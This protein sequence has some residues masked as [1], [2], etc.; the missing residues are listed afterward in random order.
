[1]APTPGTRF[2]AVFVA[3][4]L[5]AG[6]SMS[7]A[8]ADDEHGPLIAPS[9]TT[10]SGHTHEVETPA[11]VRIME[12]GNARRYA[13]GQ[14]V[15]YRMTVDQTIQARGPYPAPP[16]TSSLELLL[17]ETVAASDRGLVVTLEV[18]E[19]AAEGFLAGAEEASALRRK[20][21]YRP[22]DEIRRLVLEQGPDGKPDLR[23]AGT[24]EGYGDL[25]AIR[26]VD[27]A[28]R[29]HLLN[30]VLP[31]ERHA[32][33]DRFEETAALPAGWT[34]GYQT[35]AG[36]MTVGSREERDEREVVNLSATHV[37]TDTL[38]RVRGLDNAVEALQGQAEP[39]PNDFFAGT[40][41]HA[42]FPQGSTYESVIPPLPLQPATNPRN[43]RKAPRRR[44]PARR[45]GAPAV[46]ACLLLL[47]LA[48]CTDPQRNVDVVSLNLSGP[49]QMNHRSVVD[50]ATGVLISS[51]VTAS[52][53]LTGNVYPIPPAAAALVPEHLSRLSQAAI[54]MDADWTITQRLEG[55]LPRP[56][57]AAALTGPGTIVVGGAVAL[58]LAAALVM[59]RRR[60]GVPDD[61]APE[62]EPEGPES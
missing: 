20:V 5:A 47:G 32:E 34:L 17:T 10:V 14:T 12:G 62:P 1:M 44:R 7:A 48:G 30:P 59:R 35:L 16:Q 18:T 52:A 46:L 36:S 26:M 58:G 23:D 11:M 13:E 56:G 53:R 61:V 28:L 29:A 3:V 39:V 6:S 31:S 49:I 51:D 15:R 54:G 42:L 55:E 41:F 25:G 57:L 24:V 19:A 4:L 22:D 38:L 27:L 21:S 9:P 2:L 37:T 50:E 45:R 43:A 8:R 60:N 40:L 33:G